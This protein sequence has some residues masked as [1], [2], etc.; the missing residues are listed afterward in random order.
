M[1]NFDKFIGSIAVS[2]LQVGLGKGTK[3]GF[4]VGTFC[5]ASM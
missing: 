1:E 3:I 5:R 2:V 4:I